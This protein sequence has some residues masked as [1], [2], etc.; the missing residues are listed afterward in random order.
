MHIGGPVFAREPCVGRRSEAGK[1]IYKRMIDL[2]ASS[3]FD[4]GTL[5][6]AGLP[7]AV[8]DCYAP[9]SACS[10]RG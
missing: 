4:L 10:L 7:S 1:K 5:A 6:A 2:G 9:C 8:V 3:F